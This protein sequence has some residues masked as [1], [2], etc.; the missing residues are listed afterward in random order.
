MAIPGSLHQAKATQSVGFQKSITGRICGTRRSL[1]W[2]SDG[3]T[4]GESQPVDDDTDD[5]MTALVLP[6]RT[7]PE[8]RVVKCP[9]H[10]VGRG[11]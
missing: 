9:P 4:D 5:A 3:M 7:C 11:L 8:S 10:G 2:T 1:N 6:Q